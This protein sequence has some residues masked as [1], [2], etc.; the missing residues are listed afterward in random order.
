M[1]EKNKNMTAEHGGKIYVASHSLDERLRRTEYLL[2][3]HT[4][5][6]ALII[7]A[8]FVVAVVK[9]DTVL[10]IIQLVLT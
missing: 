5:I 6:L 9:W 2:I 10:K 7:Y 3:A 4:L 1:E 8:L